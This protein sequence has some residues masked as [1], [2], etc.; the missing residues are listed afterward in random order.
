MITKQDITKTLKEAGVVNVSMSRGNY[1]DTPQAIKTPDNKFIKGVRAGSIGPM[2]MTNQH[3]QHN[4]S[5]ITEVYTK[6]HDLPYEEIERHTTGLKAVFKIS[7]KMVRVITFD[8][9]LFPSNAPS[10]NLDSG[11]QTYWLVQ[12]IEDKKI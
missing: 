5:K 10:V 12:S 9:K 8:L 1:V 6:L 3:Q 4:Q 7:E 2:T 11:Y